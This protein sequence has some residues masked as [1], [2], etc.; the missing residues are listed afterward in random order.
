MRGQEVGD[1]ESKACELL[2]G[3]DHNMH[4][5]SQMIWEEVILLL[6]YGQTDKHFMTCQLSVIT[7]Q[8][9]ELSLLLNVLNVIY[10]FFIEKEKGD[11]Y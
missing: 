3:P 1:T 6:D 10:S 9:Q 11:L 7:Y 5:V 4:L 8:C 2:G